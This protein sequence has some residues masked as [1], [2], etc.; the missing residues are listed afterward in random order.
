[1][2]RDAIST[3]GNITTRVDATAAEHPRWNSDRFH[4]ARRLAAGP[5]HLA[6]MTGGAVSAARFGIMEIR[7]VPAALQNHSTQTIH[8]SN[9]PDAKQQALQ[10]SSD[11]QL[12]TCRGNPP[13]R[14]PPTGQ[15]QRR[16]GWPTTAKTTEERD[17][18]Q[19]VSSTYGS[20][21]QQ[22][23]CCMIWWGGAAPPNI[24][25]ST[26]HRLP[27]HQV[28]C[29]RSCYDTFV[30]VLWLVLGARSIVC[31][32][33]SHQDCAQGTRR[34]RS[35]GQ[36]LHKAQVDMVEPLTNQRAN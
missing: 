34:G 8:G 21:R 4:A 11:H 33:G 26:G 6:I 27:H 13:P 16:L 32:W 25:T 5:H 3:L 17:Y 31:T 29:G 15:L 23:T 12:W 1:M 2:A 22:R 24:T 35:A 14:Q 28:S 19:I 18:N 20:Y 9:A 36:F 30:Q 10:T 7:N